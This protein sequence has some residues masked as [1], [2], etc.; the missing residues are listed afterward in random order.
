[1]K[2][3]QDKLQLYSGDEGVDMQALERALTL[4]KRRGEG[5][6]TRPFGW[7]RDSCVYDR[8]LILCIVKC[9]IIVFSPIFFFLYYP[10]SF[11][12][13]SFFSSSDIIGEDLIMLPEVKRKLEEGQKMVYLI[14]LLIFFKS[15]R[16]Y[17]YLLLII[18]IWFA[19]YSSIFSFIWLFEKHSS[20]LF[21]A[22]LFASLLIFIFCLSYI[23]APQLNNIHFLFLYSFFYFFYFVVQVMNLKL[24]EEVEKLETMLK[25]QSS[26]NKDLHQVLDCVVLCCI[27]L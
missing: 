25:L 26:I 19:H 15:V 6:K 12:H 17:I 20:V 2:H 18:E 10:F 7:E 5:L 16:L 13:F 22:C 9:I 21:F 8:F 27:V 11:S 4:V 24:T 14:D 23:I 3:T 1:M